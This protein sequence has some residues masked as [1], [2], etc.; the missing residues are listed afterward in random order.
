[1]R[2]R[3]SH[4]Q[5][6]RLTHTHTQI[7]RTRTEKNEK[8]LSGGD[9]IISTTQHTLVRTH[10][11]KYDETFI[12]KG[13]ADSGPKYFLHTSFRGAHILLK[14]FSYFRVG[15]VRSSRVRKKWNLQTMKCLN[16]AHAAPYKAYA[17]AGFVCLSFNVN[18]NFQWNM[19]VKHERICASGRHV[20]TSTALKLNSY[21]FS[22]VSSS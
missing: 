2:A 1:M 12:R 20:K 3:S 6:R 11:R 22:H 5:C 7:Q 17:P 4:R 9:Y 10:R 16:V 21:F 14:K 19:K 13:R 18:C 15:R 8:L